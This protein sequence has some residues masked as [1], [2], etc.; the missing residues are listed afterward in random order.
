MKVALGQMAAVQGEP[1]ANV[2]K[3]EEMAAQAAENG[4][5]LICFPELS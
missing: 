4:A 2:K 1:K 5:E 3:M